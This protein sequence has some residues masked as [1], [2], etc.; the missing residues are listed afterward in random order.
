MK[1][2]KRFFLPLLF[3]T[4]IFSLFSCEES[5]VSTEIGTAEFSIMVPGDGAKSAAVTDSTVTAYQIMLSV[6]DLQGN[7]VLTDKMIP[8]YTFGTEFVSEK[9]E[10]RTGEFRLTKFMV[11]NASGAVIYAAPVAGAPLAYLCSKPLP[12]HFAIKTGEVTKVLPEVLTVGNQSPAQFGYA[13][14]GVQV[15]KPLDLWVVAV[16]DN[17]LIMAPTQMTNARLTVGTLTPT[18]NH[19][20]IRGGSD[21]YYF[22][23]EKDGYQGQKFEFTGAQVIAST[24]ANPIYLKIP[25]NLLLKTFI[26]QPGPE[27]G[28][29]AMI[30]NLEPEKNFGGHKYFEATFLSEQMLTVMRSNRS[31]IFFKLDSLPQAAQIKSVRLKLSYDLPIPFDNNTFKPDVFPTPGLAWFGGVLQQIVEPWDENAVTWNKQPKSV[32][33]NQVFIPPFI[34]NAN[35][36]EVDITRLFVTPATNALPNHGMMFKLWP[37]DKF[38]G[39]RFASSDFSE[40][41]MRPKLT[42]YYTN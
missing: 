35:F 31:M 15:I 12:F 1:T 37:Q 34:R 18:I 9:I 33:A 2:C 7:P 8:L 3:T 11:V 20:I 26:L 23:L 40:P 13:S 16:L 24:N 30:S 42:V 22:V 21:K 5:N 27:N 6:T 29:D 10:I 4:A 39:F 25:Q 19:L 14:F 32:E 38:P 36:I 28:K 17:P 41:S